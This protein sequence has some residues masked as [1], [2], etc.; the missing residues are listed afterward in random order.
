MI[1][2]ILKPILKPFLRSVTGVAKR[3]VY[4]FDG[5]DDRAAP[6][7]PYALVNGGY[8][9]CSFV[10]NVLPIITGSA[11]TLFGVTASNQFHTRA[12]IN[13]DGSITT[14]PTTFGA[15]MTTEVGLIQPLV[16][17]TYLL[18][19]TEDLYQVYVNGQLKSSLTVAG[20]Q[21][22]IEQVGM[23]G[24]LRCFGGL[25]YDVEMG[26]TYWP[27]NERAYTIQLPTP[28]GLGVELIIPAVL[29]NPASKGSQ[30]TYLGVGRWQYVG[31]GTLNELRFLSAENCPTTGLIDFEVESITG[32]M[33][34]LSANS[35]SSQF[36]TTGRKRFFYTS[37]PS[38]GICFKRAVS[39]PAAS[40]IIKNI[41]FKPLGTCNPMTLVNTTS[42]RWQEV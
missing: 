27:I 14:R 36:G 15:E 12:L 23:I 1:K 21:A 17:Y 33:T 30:W 25:I 11:P 32:T 3:W 35:G 38:D 8:F 37:L 42:D 16:H 28:T 19:R 5:V 13:P 34:W 6:S 10:L 24:G 4:N 22:T 9:K 41:S 7:S 26:G 2:P 20:G 31:D 18:T 39:T 29:E 40:C